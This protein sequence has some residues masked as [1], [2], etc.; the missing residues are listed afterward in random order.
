MLVKYKNEQG[1]KQS[2]KSQIIRFFKALYNRIHCDRF[3]Q[4]TK[5]SQ[6]VTFVTVVCDVFVI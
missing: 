3:K 1:H 6:M 5:S 2:Q 4:V